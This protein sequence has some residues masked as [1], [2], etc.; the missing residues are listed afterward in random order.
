MIQEHFIVT[1]INPHESQMI[2]WLKQQCV[3]ILKNENPY[4]KEKL[5]Q[6][7]LHFHH[8]KWLATMKAQL[9]W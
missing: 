5:L 3:D 7:D 9:S 2:Q 6:V 8:V 1:E 4:S